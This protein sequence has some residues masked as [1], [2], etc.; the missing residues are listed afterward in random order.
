MG[1]SCQCENW[2]K[3]PM[4]GVEERL[5]PAFYRCVPDCLLFVKPLRCFSIFCIILAFL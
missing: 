2:G 5:C 3:A 1:F 4:T